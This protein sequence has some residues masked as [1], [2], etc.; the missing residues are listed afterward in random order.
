MAP[1]LSPFSPSV[2]Q[3]P[4]AAPF[5]LPQSKYIPQMG[6]IWRMYSEWAK[7]NGEKQRN[8]TDAAKHIFPLARFD[9]ELAGSGCVELHKV[10]EERLAAVLLAHGKLRFPWEASLPRAVEAVWKL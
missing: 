4:C 3:V 9:D 2:V 8:V 1:C 5:S 7:L 6:Y 10:E